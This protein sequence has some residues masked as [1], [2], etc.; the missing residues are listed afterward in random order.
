MSKKTL[1]TKLRD[2]TIAQLDALQ[3]VVSCEDKAITSNQIGGKLR[4]GSGKSL[5]VLNSLVK[6]EPPAVKKLGK[7]SARQGV[8]WVYNKDFGSRD[9]VKGLVSKIFKEMVEA[10]WGGLK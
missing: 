10:G 8:L 6:I 5:T 9:D 4:F 3:A 1:E 7:I 2:M